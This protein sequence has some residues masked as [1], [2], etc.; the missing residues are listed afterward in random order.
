MLRIYFL[1]LLI[2]GLMSCGGGDNLEVIENLDDNG[3]LLE[4]YTRTKDTYAKEGLFQAFYPDGTVWI[5]AYYKNDSLVGE[6]KMYYESGSIQIIEN[7]NN[8]IFT[9]KY[10]SFYE[11]GQLDITGEYVNNA[12]EG[13]WKRYYDTGELMEVVVF[14][15]NNENGPFKE[16]YKNGNLQAEGEYLNGEF[17]HG[18]LKEYDEAGEMTS[19]KQCYKGI[20]QTIWTKE[21]GDVEFDEVAFKERVERM[22]AIEQ[23]Q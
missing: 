1:V 20:C 8:G 5:E 12:M 22:K 10:E 13:E 9:G 3:K 16:Y 17:E 4:K 21:G 7:Y 2:G 18:L 15:G 19:R 6:R 11:N 14:K 23:A